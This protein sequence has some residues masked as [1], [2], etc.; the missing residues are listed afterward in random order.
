MDV[1]KQAVCETPSEA[2]CTGIICELHFQSIATID[3]RT[4]QRSAP[5]GLLRIL[6]GSNV[7]TLSTDV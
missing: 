1:I 4:K 6:F 2:S 5:I 7:P 3:Y